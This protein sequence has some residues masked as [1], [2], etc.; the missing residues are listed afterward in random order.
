LLIAAGIGA[1]AVG[2]GF[3]GEWL[4]KKYFQSGMEPAGDSRVGYMDPSASAAPRM[5]AGA[6][7]AN[8]Q[9]V[10]PPPMRPGIAGKTYSQLEALIQSGESSKKG[11]DDYN[12]SSIGSKHGYAG[13]PV[14]QMTIQEVQSQQSQHNY[15][16]VGRYQMIATTLD[17]AV[18]FLHLDPSTTFDMDTQDYIF[19]SYLIT[20]KQQEIGDYISG[21]SD[22]L[23]GAVY[24]ASKEWA[25]VAAPP[26]YPLYKGGVS[27]GLTSYYSGLQGNKASISAIQMAQT[28]QQ[29]RQ[30]YQLANGGK[31]S[32]QDGVATQQVNQQ[33]APA[34]SSGPTA[35][36]IGGSQGYTTP[37]IIKHQGVLLAVNG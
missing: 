7:Q 6:A 24:A 37:N 19:E 34:Q 36:V 16:A 22:D 3:V 27:D 13:K 25:S 14:S 12:F 20:R 28:L 35:A 4:F 1:V 31:S 18:E 5:P 11:Y 17:A 29:E 8:T 23:W 26:S 30:N 33:Q 21:K 2:L 15:N 32:V 10:P 9:Y